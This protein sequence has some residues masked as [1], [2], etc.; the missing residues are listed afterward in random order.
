MYW[1]EDVI[2]LS[3]DNSDGS[4]EVLIALVLVAVAA[5]L[6]A[7]AWPRLGSVKVA[8]SASPQ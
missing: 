6:V 4:V 7:V 8:S 3:P 5:A 2:A 1:I